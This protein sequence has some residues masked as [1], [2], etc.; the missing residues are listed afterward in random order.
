M[1]TGA[2]EQFVELVASG[3]PLAATLAARRVFHRAGKSEDGCC[4]S[5]GKVLRRMDFAGC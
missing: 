4:C 2:F 3:R 1:T 5:C